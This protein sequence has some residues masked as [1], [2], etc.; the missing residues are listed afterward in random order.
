MDAPLL[1][2][3]RGAP[4]PQKRRILCTDVWCVA[5]VGAAA[6][7]AIA[8]VVCCV[9]PLLWLR[10][11]WSTC[12]TACLAGVDDG[13]LWT[14]DCRW[15]TD[16]GNAFA[17]D[18][19]WEWMVDFC[20][21]AFIASA[22]GPMCIGDNGLYGEQYCVRIDGPFTAAMNRWTV[23]LACSCTVAA[24]FLCVCAT[25]L[26]AAICAARR[27]R[28]DADEQNVE[29]SIQAEG[30]VAASVPKLEHGGSCSRN[31]RL[32]VSAAVTLGV[33]VAGAATFETAVKSGV[34]P[35]YCTNDA[36][37][38]GCTLYSSEAAAS[39]GYDCGS[40][41]N[42]PAPVCVAKPSSSLHKGFCI[43]VDRQYAMYRAFGIALAVAGSGA[44]AYFVF[45]TWRVCKRRAGGAAVCGAATH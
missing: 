33:L 45:R 32:A 19:F 39:N 38:G 9:L 24:L 22:D 35:P 10:W 31:R 43:T 5:D 2:A 34:C 41:M 12:D 25:S 20:P 13:G 27:S 18:Y 6:A 26:Y 21:P 15:F 40:Y 1:A 37:F 36:A 14:A 3:Q 4:A 28:A 11:T 29:A 17:Q 23:L 42:A 16:L 30:T 7:S 8:V 44:L